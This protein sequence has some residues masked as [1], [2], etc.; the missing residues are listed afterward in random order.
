MVPVLKKTKNQELLN[1]KVFIISD[2]KNKLM[3]R[4]I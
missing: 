2:I 1:I 3:F 4:I